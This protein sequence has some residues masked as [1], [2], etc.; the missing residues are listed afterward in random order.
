[1]MTCN[2]HTPVHSLLPIFSLPSD[3]PQRSA[4]AG[5]ILHQIVCEGLAAIKGLRKGDQ[6]C[7]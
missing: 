6:H 4:V 2:K 3:L 5:G 1:M 7:G